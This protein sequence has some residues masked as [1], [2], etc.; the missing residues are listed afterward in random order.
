VIGVSFSCVDRK[1]YFEHLADFLI[2]SGRQGKKAGS[3]DRHD[4][5]YAFMRSIFYINGTSANLRQGVM[6]LE[7]I[8]FG[9]V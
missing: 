8:L 9:Y 1:V 4:D 6:C 7:T 3:E 5:G 2:H